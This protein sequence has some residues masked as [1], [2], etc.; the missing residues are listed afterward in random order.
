MYPERDCSVKGEPTAGVY[1]FRIRGVEADRMGAVEPDW[2]T[3]T[4]VREQGRDPDPRVPGTVDVRDSTATIWVADGGRI[5]VDRASG[6]VRI[7]TP[8]PVSD[9]AV[10]HP[11]LALPAAFAARWRGRRS[12]HGGAFVHGDGAVALLG[13]KGGGKSSTLG[14][15]L[16]RGHL[17][18]TDDILVLDGGDVF[19]GP[20]AVD[21]RAETAER[22]GGE[23]LG[24][25]GARPRWRLHPDPAPPRTRLRGIVQLEWG[26]A[27][28]L[29]PAG[30]AE[31]LRGLMAACVLRPDER[32]A[33]E[34]LDLAAL[35][36]WRL[37]RPLSL[38]ALEPG[39]DQLLAALA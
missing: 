39:V 34:L 13:D 25:V 10:L 6:T 14:A 36:T 18:L 16:A 27:I 17:V 4:V 20:R 15:L 29:T 19:A 32:D 21:L 12:L 37:Q 35:P 23:A 3:L 30:P 2:A 11:Y 28:A 7:R 8:E 33:L 31:R 1:G 9:D 24:V 26:D 22:L 5:D 38:E